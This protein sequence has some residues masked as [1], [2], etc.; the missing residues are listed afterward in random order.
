LIGALMDTHDDVGN[1]EA[2]IRKRALRKAMLL[3]K[4]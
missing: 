3:R 2:A 4:A 1:A